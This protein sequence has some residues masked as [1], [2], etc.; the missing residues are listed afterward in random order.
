MITSMRGLAQVL[1][2]NKDDWETPVELFSELNSRFEFDLD[3]AASDDNALCLRYFTKKDDALGQVWKGNVFCNPPYSLSR[4][5]IHAAWSQAVLYELSEVV[6]LLVAA[7][8]SNKEWHKYV[9]PHASELI[10][11]NGRVRFSNSSA[12]APFPS[13]VVVFKKGGRPQGQ[14]IKVSTLSVRINNDDTNPRPNKKKTKSSN[15]GLVD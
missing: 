4:E 3:A 14:D 8:T 6:C 15:K 10:F 7:R 13:V 1:A 5:F 2:S 12:G 9:F 11:I